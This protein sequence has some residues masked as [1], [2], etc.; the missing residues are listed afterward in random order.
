MSHCKT[1]PKRWNAVITCISD[2][3][4]HLPL[5]NYDVLWEL[6]T[7]LMMLSQLTCHLFILHFF[8]TTTELALIL[9]QRLCCQQLY[10]LFANSPQNPYWD[11]QWEA[12]SHFKTWRYL[13]L[14]SLSCSFSEWSHALC[15]I[16]LKLA[17]AAA[18]SPTPDLRKAAH[19]LLT[20]GSCSGRGVSYS[21]GCG[22]SFSGDVP[23]QVRKSSS[24]GSFMHSW[25]CCRV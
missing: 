3:P 13:Y 23:E 16:W 12:A 4:D 18:A 19:Q 6:G 14:H 22:V 8:F 11:I 15:N 2:S 25:L 20:Y 9:S 17:T 7:N 24:M 10:L 21:C 5:N 1:D